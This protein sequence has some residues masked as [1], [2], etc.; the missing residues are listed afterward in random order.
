LCRHH[1]GKVAL[2]DV[3]DFMGEHAGEFGLALRAEQ[4]ARMHAD[5]SA[6][7]CEC[8]DGIV[9]DSE[10]F[11]RAG[12]IWTVADQAVANA[13]QIV[14]NV[15]IV[16]VGRVGANLAHDPLAEFSFLGGGQRAL[17]NIAQVGQF[18][19]ETKCRGQQDHNHR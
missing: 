8:V 16:D 18:V 10:K 1:A 2:G 11:E 17:G 14:G 15:G 6:R 5:E 12:R 9:G 4:Q 13:V 19:G 7:Q 3:R